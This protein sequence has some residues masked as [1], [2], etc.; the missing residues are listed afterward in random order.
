MNLSTSQRDAP[1]TSFDVADLTALFSRPQADTSYN[2]LFSRCVLDF[3]HLHCEQK[4]SLVRAEDGTSRGVP[5]AFLEDFNDVT[6]SLQDLNDERHETAHSESEGF[7]CITLEAPN[8]VS[9]YP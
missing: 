7:L 8:T 6:L 2:T 3:R 9:S 5:V 1:S 4:F